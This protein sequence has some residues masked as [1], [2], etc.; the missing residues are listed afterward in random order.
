MSPVSKRDLLSMWQFFELLREDD[1]PTLI[2]VALVLNYVGQS[3][4]SHHPQIKKLG[5]GISLLAFASYAL[6]EIFHFG[7]QGAE[8]LFSIVFR[9]LIIAGMMLG[10]TWIIMS[11]I[12]F[13]FS[14]VDNIKKFF[15][16]SRMRSQQ[17]KER[18][19]REEENQQQKKRDQQEWEQMAPERECRQ[20]KQQATAKKQT[21]E[22]HKR[23][24]IRLSCQLLYDQH[25]IELQ[26]RFPRERLNEYFNQYLSDRFSVK[27]V[28]QRGL[29]LK[30]M[31]ESSLEQVKGNRQ[32]YSSL[33]EIASYFRKQKQ[34]I[35][36]LDY[37]VS[38]RQS[39]LSSLNHQEDR[40]IREFLS[41]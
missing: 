14:P 24:E 30:E 18:A 17:K 19:K 22:Q 23:E 29:L 20:K 40:A 34:E 16:E 21:N 13:L 28:E 2:G 31:I 11:I 7:I 10:T 4:V 41:S 1:I 35:E 32:K 37:D 36:S 25:A 26:D 27:I 8:G 38:T 6:I 9:G 15:Q 33:N 5:Y 39:F 12:T 3:A